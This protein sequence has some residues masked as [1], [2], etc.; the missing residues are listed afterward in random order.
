MRA[1]VQRVNQA[2]VIVEGKTI[3]EIDRGIVILLGIANSDKIE[4]AAYLANKISGLRIF[5]DEQGKLNLSLQD[6]NGTALVVS[7]FTL[8]GDCRKGRRPSYSQAAPPE[9]ANHI[10]K[11]FIKLLQQTGTKTAN[12]QFQTH[13]LVQI[14]NDG[15]VTLIVESR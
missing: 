15:P 11:Q 12:G 6:I 10:Y 4:D 8:L 2:R 1:V 14:H 5:D 7:Q 13:M 9:Q 3:A